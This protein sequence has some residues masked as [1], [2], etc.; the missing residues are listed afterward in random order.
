MKAH[1]ETP[2]SGSLGALADIGEKQDAG[3]QLASSSSPPDV[4]G[5]SQHGLGDVICEPHIP[6]EGRQEM[7]ENKNFKK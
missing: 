7:G 4:T 2:H 3:T 5:T 1:T 6:R